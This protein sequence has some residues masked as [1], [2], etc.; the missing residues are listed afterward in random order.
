MQIIVFKVHEL[1]YS[2]YIHIPEQ[3]YWKYSLLECS[4]KPSN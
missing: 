4:F 1:Q 3:E 2:N